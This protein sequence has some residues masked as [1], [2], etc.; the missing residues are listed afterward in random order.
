MTEMPE[1]L[2]T[3]E[4]F[5]K[6]CGRSTWR[7]R[8]CT[9]EGRLVMHGSETGRRAAKYAAERALFQMLLTAP[10]WSGRS[11]SVTS[12]TEARP[13]PRAA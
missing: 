2:P 8:V 6:K 4:T 9:T 3:F 13:T 10:Y 12:P 5:L 11:A 7:W 1:I